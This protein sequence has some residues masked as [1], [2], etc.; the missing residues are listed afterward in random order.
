[1][2]L[3]SP[4]MGVEKMGIFF[5]S[6]DLNMQRQKICFFGTNFLKFYEVRQRFKVWKKLENAELTALLQ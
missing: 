6:P 1:M 2:K 3:P 5:Y 4:A